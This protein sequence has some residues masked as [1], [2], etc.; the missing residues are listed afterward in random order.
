VIRRGGRATKE[1]DMNRADMERERRQ[2]KKIVNSCCEVSCQCGRRGGGGR[3]Q[4]RSFAA[5]GE[6]QE[7]FRA[8][9]VEG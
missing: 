4:I 3:A 2:G 6:G 7:V 5:K 8:K 9:E 1:G